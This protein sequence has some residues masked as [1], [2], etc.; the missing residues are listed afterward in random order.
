MR[1][2]K[3]S[4]STPS[5]LWSAVVFSLLASDNDLSD[6]DL[7]KYSASEEAFLRLLPVIKEATIVSLTY[8]DLSP[9]SCN[10]LPLVLNSKLSSLQYL[11]ISNNDLYD[12]GVEQLCLGLKSEECELETLRLSGCVVSEKGGAC[13]VSALS[14]NSSRLKQLDLSYN[15]PQD[16]TIEI[17]TALQQDP[18]NS[19]KTLIVEPA[20]KRYLCAGLR[21]YLCDLSLD[22][23]S[24]HK[25]L[26]L[27]N[28]HTVTVT[29]K[30]HYPDHP[31]RFDS[32]QKVICSTGLT[33]RCY[34]EV[35]WRGQ[36]SN[37]D[38]DVAV[39]YS[40][41]ARKGDI[42]FGLNDRSW[43]LKISSGGYSVL[44]GG[45][46]TRVSSSYTATDRVAVYLDRDA[47]TLSFYKIETNDGKLL[48][49]HTFTT[50]FTEPL[51]AGFGFDL[52][53]SGVTVSF[54]RMLD[55]F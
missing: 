52:W 42:R 39:S 10:S 20:E 23:N 54:D 48:H 40:T 29:D 34:W 19:L 22:P 17:L 36:W 11:D 32:C 4:S 2:G 31:D 3:L 13:L 35:D 55:D 43:C 24:A 25:H 6:F 30:D 7:K 33:G 28:S 49:L 45:A 1:E 15:H 53:S 16:T 44:H 12:D 47:G 46:H 50:T 26:K 41:T 21:K 9:A 51:C 37:W 5:S 27:R 8:C 38:V 14:P 18:H